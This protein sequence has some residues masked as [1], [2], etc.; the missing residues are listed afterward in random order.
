MLEA[1]GVQPAT[2]VVIVPAPSPA[3]ATVA[4]ET[5]SQSNASLNV[6]SSTSPGPA[7]EVPSAVI[8]PVKEDTKADQPSSD[9]ASA[10][11]TQVQLP[12]TEPSGQVEAVPQPSQ[13]EPSTQLQQP[14]QPQPSSQ[15]P[16]QPSTQPPPQPATQPQSLPTTQQLTQQEMQMPLQQDAHAQPLL[17]VEQESI[18]TLSTSPVLTGLLYFSFNLKDF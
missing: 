12:I 4:T 1:A 17:K 16:T 5:A 11:P 6:A 3:P 18:T 15:Q 10:K 13:A 2:P 9:S 7:Q 14:T 8:S